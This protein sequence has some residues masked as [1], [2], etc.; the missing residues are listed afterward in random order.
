MNVQDVPLLLR[1]EIEARILAPFV[2]ELEDEFGADP[3]RAVLQRTIRG[4]ARAQGEAMARRLGGNSLTHLLQVLAM[5]RQGG[6]LTVD[7]IHHDET[8]LRFHVT[9]C[10]YAEMYRAL[11]L[12][13]LGATLSCQRD[14]AFLEGFNPNLRFER[15]HTLMEGHDFCDF[16]YT[17]APGGLSETQEG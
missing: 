1:R 11:G 5:W 7:M 16:C 15:K 6:A 14:A 17:S 4:V 3:V 10:A 13:H 2:R 9:R 12:A 8:T